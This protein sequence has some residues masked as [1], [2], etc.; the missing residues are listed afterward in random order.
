M[1][2][3]ITYDDT[4]YQLVPKVPT[5][6]MFDAF[7]DAPLLDEGDE[8]DWRK[9]YRAML[10]AA[11]TPPAQPEAVRVPLTDEDVEW[12][13]N[14]LGE[15]GVKIGNQFFWLYKGY[16]LVYEDAKHDDGSPMMWRI[17]GKREFGETCKPIIHLKVENGQIYDRTP[18]PYRQEL[19]Y[20]P[21]L[22]DGKPEDGA[23]KPLPPAH[24]ITAAAP[25]QEPKD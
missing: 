17:V 14:D 20:T 22:S 3:S 10:S 18:Y 12:V 24:G 5:Q 19:V 6:A 4:L 21:G 23:W 11:P 16:S 13:V 8:S 25:K 2:K 7:Y 1:I 15:L 9:S